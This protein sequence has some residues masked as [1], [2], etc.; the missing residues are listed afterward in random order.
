MKSTVLLE[1]HTISTLQ[2]AGLDPSSSRGYG[3]PLFQILQVLK[4]RTKTALEL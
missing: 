2:E 3:C 4:V 1:T